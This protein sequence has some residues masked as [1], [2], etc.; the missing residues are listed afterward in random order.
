MQ[1]KEA[2]TLIQNDLDFSERK[3]WADLGCGSGLFTKALASLLV[4]GSTI[5]AVDENKTAL[6]AVPDHPAITINRINKDF[7]HDQLPFNHIDAVLMANS[8]HYV[9][10]KNLFLEKIESHM[11][12]SRVFIIVEYNTDTP[13]R[14]VPFPLSFPALKKLFEQAGY[15]SIKQLH[16]HPSIY[17]RADMYSAI[18]TK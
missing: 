2:I 17:N 3:I 5:Y 14:W 12:P 9:A 15:H 1:L 8:L 13:N 16:T 7:V 4:P 10:D 18:I 6:R 11:N